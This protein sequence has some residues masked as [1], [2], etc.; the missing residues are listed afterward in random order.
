MNNELA[1]ALIAARKQLDDQRDGEVVDV[2]DMVASLHVGPVAIELAAYR[3]AIGSEPSPND[4]AAVLGLV[5]QGFQMGTS[6]GF[7]EAWV[8][9]T[10][11][12]RPER[13]RFRL[14]V[15]DESGYRIGISNTGPFVEPSSD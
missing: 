2:T 6:Q 4:R 5:S 11:S 8:K 3:M 7:F 10:H 13:H 12:D 1:Q 14:M 15:R 9:P